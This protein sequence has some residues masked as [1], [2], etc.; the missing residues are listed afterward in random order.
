MKSNRPSSQKQLSLVAGYKMQL[1]KNALQLLSF[2]QCIGSSMQSNM[3][4]FASMTL[5]YVLKHFPP[6]FCMLLYLYFNSGLMLSLYS[7]QHMLVLQPSCSN[8][9]CSIGLMNSRSKSTYTR[10]LYLHLSMLQQNC[11]T[12]KV[13]MNLY[14]HGMSIF[15][16]MYLT[17]NASS[18]SFVYYD[19]VQSVQHTQYM[20]ASFSHPPFFLIDMKHL[21]ASFS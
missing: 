16:S 5:K 1:L 15:V 21:I 11:C 3:G 17:S 20:S 2:D 6:S 9:L 19:T 7:Q 14:E 18:K 10:Y 12:Y 8:M 4:V 13:F